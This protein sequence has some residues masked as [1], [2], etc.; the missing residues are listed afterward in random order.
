[1]IFVLISST[2]LHQNLPCRTEFAISFSDV[3]QTALKISA[4]YTF[5][6][7]IQK[8]MVTYDAFMAEMS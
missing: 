2:K 4:I 8:K 7:T 5:S 1:M 6:P 3:P